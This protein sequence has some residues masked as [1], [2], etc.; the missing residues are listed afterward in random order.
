[1]K[2]A[3]IRQ[4]VAD[5]IRSEGCSCC[6]DNDVH[7]IHEERLAKLLY[8]EMYDDGSGFDFYQYCSPEPSIEHKIT[9]KLPEE[10]A[11]KFK[12]PN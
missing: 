10:G 7:E 3:E 5:Y 6:R 2:K 4:A 8:V 9:Y 1:M 12:P 11:P